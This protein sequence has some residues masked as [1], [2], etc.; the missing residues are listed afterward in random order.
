M[1][2]SHGSIPGGQGPSATGRLALS[3][4]IFGLN[5]LVQGLGGLWTGSL[6]LVSD[7][8]ENLND[9]AVN[10]LALGSIRL[11]NRREPCDRWTYGWH[12]IEIFNTLLGVFLLVVLAGAVLFEAWDRVRHPHAIKLGW[13]IGFSLLGLALNLAA[14]FV[15]VPTEGTGQERD[16]N[17]RSAYLHALGDS[18]ANVAVVAGMVVIHFTGWRWVD[19]LLAA[20]ISM[21]ILRGAYLLLRDAV[22]ILMHRA[23][24]DQEAAKTDLLKLPGILGVED[25]RSWRVCSHLTVCTAHII[26]EV[27]RLVD[28]EAHQQRVEHLLCD[29]YG[30]RHLTLHFETAAMAERHLHRFVHEHEAE[31][32][33]HHDHD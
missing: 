21:V 22:G 13:A 6:G 12:R 9:A 32:H 14:T 18:L 30:V 28:T 31:G 15:L 17:L 3:S 7:S 2:H 25:L 27:E 26:V 23:A 8:L 1:S 29:H 16:L 5:F 24:F 19:P 33:H 11:A 4:L 20:G 10:L